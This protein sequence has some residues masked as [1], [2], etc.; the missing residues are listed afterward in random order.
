MMRLV[1]QCLVCA[2]FLLAPQL[3]NA[4]GTALPAADVSAFKANPG[5]LLTQF[6][7]GGPGL[8]KR[9]SDL[10]ASDRATLAQIIAIAKPANQD[11]RKA[12]AAA[13]A[14]TAKA[15]AAN[16]PA[17]ANQ[18][19]QAVASSGLP[20]FA[21]AYAESAGDTGTA[22]TGGGGGSGGGPVAG[23]PIGG[24]NTGGFVPS[25]STVTNNS[26]VGIPGSIGNPQCSNCS[27]SVSL[28]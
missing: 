21:K 13:L 9:V 23:P 20:E 10:V 12:I 27:N 15:Y 1:I 5:Q 11:Q 26:N 24:P 22:S 3:V 14:E 16:D 6:P 7:D 25:N 19:Q 17:F 28:F 4:Q 8:T 18:I 2:F